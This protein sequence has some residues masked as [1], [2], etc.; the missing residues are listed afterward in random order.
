MWQTN[1]VPLGPSVKGKIESKRYHLRSTSLSRLTKNYIMYSFIGL[2]QPLDQ[3]TPRTLYEDLRICKLR[4]P[5]S[6]NLCTEIGW[7]MFIVKKN[8]GG[9]GG[10][11]EV[12]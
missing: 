9:G 11:K 1:S 3:Y 4:K 10:L 12:N 7:A 5:F 8:G 2:N 6:N